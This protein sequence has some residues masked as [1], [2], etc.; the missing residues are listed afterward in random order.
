MRVFW[1]KGY[2]ATQ[3]GDLLEAMAIS[4]PSFYAAYTS[5]EA[6]FR[7]ALA[8][9]GA[10]DGSRSMAALNETPRARE[11]VR[12]MLMASVE[13]ALGSPTAGGCM[14]SL[15][16]VNGSEASAALRDELRELRRKTEALIHERLE[17][18]VREW[19]LRPDLD[20]ARLAAF[21]A[22]VMHGLSLQANDGASRDVLTGVVDAAMMAFDG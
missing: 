12:A 18:G 5:K 2:D 3:I 17:R 15:G 14:V 10:T 1:A 13:T 21:L 7:E 9:Y 20:T 22:T 19:D 8:R 16:L 4:P 11:A 6:L